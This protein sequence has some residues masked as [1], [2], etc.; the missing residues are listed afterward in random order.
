MQEVLEA[1]DRYEREGAKK[2]EI[3]FRNQNSH[4]GKRYNPIINCI[5][6]ILSAI[7]SKHMMR[8]KYKKCFVKWSL[9][10]GYAKQAFRFGCNPQVFADFSIVRENIYNY[11]LISTASSYLAQIPISS[12]KHLNNSVSL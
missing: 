10:R 5:I 12:Y 4:I 7:L 8:T 2:T 9:R 3:G 1:E 6:S 11:T